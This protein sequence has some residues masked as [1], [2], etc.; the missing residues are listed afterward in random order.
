MVRK[1]LI[2]FVSALALML[3]L[4]TLLPEGVPKASAQDSVSVWVMGK[5]LTES[6]PQ[7]TYGNASATYDSKTKTLTLKGKF[8]PDYS[9]NDTYVVRVDGNGVTIKTNGNVTIGSDSNAS[10]SIGIGIFGNNN[11]IVT[12]NNKLTIYA[13]DSGI[14]F[15]GTLEIADSNLYVDGDYSIEIPSNVSP[16]V[17]EASALTFS[18]SNVTLSSSMCV[19]YN[20]PTTGIY[21]KGVTFSQNDFGIYIDGSLWSTTANKPITNLV[22]TS[23]PRSYNLWICGNE[24]T[25]E[26]NL[27]FLPVTDWTFDPSTNTLIIDK[28]VENYTGSEPLVKSMIDGLKIVTR[29]P[30][31]IETQ[32]DVFELYNNATFECPEGL[33]IN[34]KNGCGIRSAGG[35]VTIKDSLMEINAKQ[36]IT[37]QLFGSTYMGNIEFNNSDVMI[38]GSEF[39]VANLSSGEGSKSIFIENCTATCPM[40]GDARQGRVYDNNAGKLATYVE[41]LRAGNYYPLYVNGLC[42]NEYNKNNIL[43]DFRNGKSAKYDPETNTLTFDRDIDCSDSPYPVLYNG[44][45]GLNVNA[46][47]PVTLTSA[48][49]K[50][51]IYADKTMT[52]TGD[53]KITVNAPKSAAIQL[54]S[55][56]DVIV[57]DVEL[58][59]TATVGIMSTG[60]G[61]DVLF[62]G[63]SA[64]ISATS[65][66]L[67]LISGDISLTNCEYLSPEDAFVY[68]HE[69]KNL[70]YSYIVGNVVKELVIGKETETR[71]VGDVNGDGNITADDAIIVAR[72]AAGYGDYAAR[73][74]SDVADMNGDGK[75]TADDAII[76]A[77]YAAGYGN[78]R[79]IYT[80]Y[81]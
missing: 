51:A 34:S 37:G 52:I 48:E 31:H 11:K 45:E 43:Y 28:N 65:C 29:H 55:N 71:L 33:Y 21:S 39:A 70:L 77:R 66:A 5:Y 35:Y 32:S 22:I 3:S 23:K 19:L 30:Q 38:D 1:R 60:T 46:S 24:I 18:Y 74:D 80:K 10:C 16:A 62:D 7:V 14:S 53:N 25:N 73:Y 49:G 78:Y 54:Q 56:A 47:V 58:D 61:N 8:E 17:Q 36:G 41:I 79:D 50:K 4:L 75:V 40:S 15:T 68:N 64:N 81:I 9:Y 27:S 12:Y 2:S 57:K 20:F 72:L 6:S 13:N 76:I 67:Y 44:I 26:S 42:V 63:A 59:I 69:G